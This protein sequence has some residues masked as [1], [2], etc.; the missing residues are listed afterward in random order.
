MF[1]QI[2]KLIN[3]QLN[4]HSLLCGKMIQNQVLSGSTRREERGM[5]SAWTVGRR[6]EDKAA[7][8]GPEPVR[9]LL[10]PSLAHNLD[11]LQGRELT[12]GQSH[13]LALC[14]SVSCPG[15]NKAPQESRGH[16]SKSVPLGPN[17]PAGLPTKVLG[18]PVPPSSWWLS[19]FLGWSTGHRVI[20]SQSMWSPLLSWPLVPSG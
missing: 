19:V 17:Q 5:V 3:G 20:S 15:C 16:E 12:G 8:Q 10:V 9:L 13:L 1:L 7:G 4:F 11:S 14:P 6:G 2:L 18:K